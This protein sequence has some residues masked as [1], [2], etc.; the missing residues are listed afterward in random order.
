[1]DSARE[2]GLSPSVIEKDY[3]LGWLLAGISNHPVLKSAWVFKGGT[4]LKK[5]FFETY[6]FSE[7]LDFTITDSEYFNQEFLT[8]AFTEIAQWLY[9][10]A[11]IEI[12]LDRLRFDVYKNTR[13]VLSAEGRVSY[14]GP[15]QMGGDPAR[16]KLDL[17]CDE[18]LVHDPVEQEVHHPYS[19]KPEGGI[20]INCYNFEEV[21][22]EKLRALAE[23]ERP[24]DLYDVIN[25]YRHYDTTID[26]ILLLDTLRKKCEFKGIAVPTMVTLEGKPE[27]TELEAEWKNMLGHQLPMLPPFEQ[28]WQELPVVFE[29]LHGAI[30]KTAPASIAATEEIDTS[31]QPPAMAQAWHREV[32]LETIRFA[33]ANR[34]CID[35]RYQGTNRLIEP[36]SLRRTKAGDILLC[37]VKHQTG[38]SRSYR[39]DRMEGVKATNISFIPK[40][41]IELTPSGPITAPPTAHKSPRPNFTKYKIPGQ[42]VKRYVIKKQSFG[43]TYVIQC[44]YC[45]KK[46]TRQKYDTHLNPHKDKNG[47]PCSGRYGAVVETKY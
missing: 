46:F 22:A 39:I 43:P 28:F 15:I 42:S 16:I 21:F 26:R 29:W 6:R 47:Y 25:L 31:W 14:R 7:D 8:S 2:F 13:G 45:G 34:L 19:D 10:A 3:A 38:Q 23:R 12:P 30:P 44:S 37:A 4:C 32:P 5:C 20:R 24:R 41:L 40:Y 33:A 11:G 1:M 27:R 35:L 17:T 9:D 18:V 36:Y